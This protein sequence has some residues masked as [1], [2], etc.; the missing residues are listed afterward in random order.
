MF[1]AI[2]SVLAPG[3]RF[4]I[5]L[6]NYERIRSAGIRQLPLSFRPLPE[7]EGA[8]E[9][10]F[11]R[12]FTPHPDGSVDFYPVTLTLRPG[13]EPPIEIRSARQGKHR[14]WTRAE[15]ERALTESGFGAIE[16]CGGMSEAPFVSGESHDLVLIATRRAG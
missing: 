1:A 5:Q 7:E 6:L 12:I 10:V 2:A 4:L 9:I 3:A 8:G 11:L 14:G 13:A 16:A 15:L